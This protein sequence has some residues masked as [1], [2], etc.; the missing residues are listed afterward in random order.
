MTVVLISCSVRSWLVLYV[1][2]PATTAEQS[3]GR[4]LLPQ[5]LLSRTCVRLGHN[6]L[7]EVVR[8]FGLLRLAVFVAQG[9][10][11]GQGGCVIVLV[12]SPRVQS[13][14][15][16]LSFDFLTAWPSHVC[17]SSLTT[18]TTR[19]SHPSRSNTALPLH[20][21]PSSS[22]NFGRA[23]ASS[24][25]CQPTEPKRLKARSRPTANP[26]QVALEPKGSPSKTIKK[27]SPKNRAGQ[28]AVKN[29]QNSECFSLRWP[30]RRANGSHHSAHPR[31]TTRMTARR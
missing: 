22:P 20:C 12:A 28:R 3:K 8:D 5:E 15:L 6:P 27:R 9:F 23:V 4:M 24:T 10:F 18:A 17:T 31:P 19:Q 25:H 14:W 13:Y 16:P 11:L 29:D 26:S 30:N 7:A 1:G 2:L 21:G